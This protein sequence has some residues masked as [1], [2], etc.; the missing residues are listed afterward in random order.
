MERFAHEKRALG[1]RG[2]EDPRDSGV[3]QSF[4]PCPRGLPSLQKVELT[5]EPGER[6]SRE[7][8]I[9]TTPSVGDG[10][11]CPGSTRPSSPRWMRFLAW[12]GL[13]ILFYAVYGYRH[14]RAAGAP[15]EATA[16][17]TTD[18]TTA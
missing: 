17:T 15:K 12:L 10:A 13:G 14:S 18:T 4:R 7:R 5:R 16:D 3:E 2:A 8:I 11:A 9:S 1:R 6:T